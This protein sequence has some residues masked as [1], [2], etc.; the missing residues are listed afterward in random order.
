[1]MS[2]KYKLFTDRYRK[3]STSK[4]LSSIKM[5][6]TEQNLQTQIWQTT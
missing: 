3:L 4:C 1:M 5:F 2:N 6:E